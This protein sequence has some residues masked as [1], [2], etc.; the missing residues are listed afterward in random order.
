M[1]S[2]WES[3]SVLANII[4]FSGNIILSM[5][6]IFICFGILE[7]IWFTLIAGDWYRASL[8]KLL[9]EEFIVWPWVVFYLIYAGAIFVLAV[10]ANR[11]KPLYYAG[12]DG[13]LLGLASYGA[14]NLTNFSVIEDYDLKIA[15][16]DWGWGIILTAMSAMVGWMGFQLNRQEA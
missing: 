5:L 13:A 3:H 6:A 10:V 4:R 11:D 8:G 9:R 14:Y 12:I 1:Y 15:M 7:S 16:V 2:F